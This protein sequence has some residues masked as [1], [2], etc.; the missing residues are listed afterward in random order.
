MKSIQQR[1]NKRIKRG[2]RKQL[3]LRTSPTRSSESTSACCYTPSISCFFSQSN[4]SPAIKAICYFCSLNESQF[5]RSR[6]SLETEIWNQ[7]YLC[8][9]FMDLTWFLLTGYDF[10]HPK[11]RTFSLRKKHKVIS[12][13][14]ALCLDRFSHHLISP[15]S[16]LPNSRR[17][18][19]NLVFSHNVHSDLNDKYSST[20]ALQ[21]AA[22]ATHG[23]KSGKHWLTIHRGECKWSSGN[24]VL[25]FS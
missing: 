11:W 14:Q 12:V 24:R 8:L 20:I 9:N 1:E 22:E 16:R 23:A 21:V 17:V 18:Q 3:S 10:S 15:A 4:L 13:N 7:S 2:A 6:S 5:K 19:L 25:F